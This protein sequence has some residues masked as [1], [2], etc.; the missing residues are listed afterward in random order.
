M[1]FK[2]G[3]HLSNECLLLDAIGPITHQGGT[4]KSNTER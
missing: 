3:G 4:E 1:N 2:K